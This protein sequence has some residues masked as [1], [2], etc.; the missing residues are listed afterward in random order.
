MAMK[1]NDFGMIDL[2]GIDPAV[3]EVVGDG[4]RR[5]KLRGMGKGQRRKVEKDA[6]RSRAMFDIPLELLDALDKIAQ[7]LRTPRSQVA[8]M[9]I[10]LAMKGMEDGTLPLPES[11]E[12]RVSESMRFEFT[13]ALP[14]IPEFFK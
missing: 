2:R 10:L 11:W 14:E 7:D 1:K 8:N 6:Q 4:R 5:R 13:L 9:L 12:K 3:A